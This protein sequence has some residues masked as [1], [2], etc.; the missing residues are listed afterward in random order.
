MQLNK[1]NHLVFENESAFKN[2]LESICCNKVKLVYDYSDEYKIIISIF[3]GLV[4][5]KT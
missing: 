3:K 1:R 2:E 4:E 5:L